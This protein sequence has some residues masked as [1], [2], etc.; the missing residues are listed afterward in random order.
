VLFSILILNLSFAE[1]SS[2]SE[3]GIIIRQLKTNL[4]VWTWLRFYL[5][6]VYEK[7]LLWRR[8]KSMAIFFFRPQIL[9]PFMRFQLLP[10]FYL[11]VSFTSEDKYA[12]NEGWRSEELIIYYVKTVRFTV[13][14]IN[15]SLIIPTEDWKPT[16][17]GLNDLDIMT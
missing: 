9:V 17:F 12:M 7:A 10:V 8:N 4:S 1:T 3:Q 16:S 14:I 2:R 13:G 6:F 11:T 5:Y 15:T